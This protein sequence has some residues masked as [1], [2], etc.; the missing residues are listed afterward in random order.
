MLSILGLL[1]IFVLEIR[2]T[3]LQLHGR[4]LDLQLMYFPDFS[5]SDYELSHIPSYFCA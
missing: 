2:Q 1:K 4:Q 5:L 3:S